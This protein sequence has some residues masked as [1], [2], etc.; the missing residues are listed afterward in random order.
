MAMHAHR[1]GT[2]SI[3]ARDPETGQF[4]VAVQSHWFSVGA[5]V[6]WARPGVGAVATQATAD[7]SYGPRA[8]DLLAAGAGANEA[9]ARLVAEDPGAATRQVAVVDAQGE[10]AVHTGATCVAFAGHVTGEACS[11]QGNLLASARVWPAMLDAFRESTPPLAERLLAALDAGEL[12]GGDARGRQSA[13]M[14]VVGPSGEPWEERISLRVEDHPAPLVELRR[15]LELHSAYSLAD[16]ADG[17]VA[18]GRQ[19]EAAQLY[20]RASALVPDSHELGF[21]AGLGL[22]QAGQMDLGLARV[23]QAIELHPGWREILERLPAEMAPAAEA[24]RERLRHY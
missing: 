24:V 20:E 11:C 6:P 1:A 17:L 7:V 8:L 5:R 16:I 18:E 14:L 3:V 21:W 22:A 4:G 12:A 23:R 9:L 15:L 19:A 13:A 2:Y 10:V